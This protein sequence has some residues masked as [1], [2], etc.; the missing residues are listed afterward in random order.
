MWP[1]FIFCHKRRNNS[2]LCLC[3]FSK[4]LCFGNCFITKIKWKLNICAV[5]FEMFVSLSFLFSS[6]GDMVGSSGCNM[7]CAACPGPCRFLTCSHVTD[8]RGAHLP[9]SWGWG[10]ALDSLV[11]LQTEYATA[12]PWGWH[13]RGRS[14]MGLWGDPCQ[15]Q[16]S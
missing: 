12:C 2:L 5:G 15:C 11:I 6:S 13:A 7:P 14:Q 8:R 3:V 16:V 4:I 1:L 10:S 9:G